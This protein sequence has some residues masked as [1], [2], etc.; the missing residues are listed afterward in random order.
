MTHNKAKL[1]QGKHVYGTDFPVKMCGKNLMT[2]MSS[3]VESIYDNDFDN[4]INSINEA[5]LTELKTEINNEET[6]KTPP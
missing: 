1:Q 3:R 5:K 4:S 2:N 6:L